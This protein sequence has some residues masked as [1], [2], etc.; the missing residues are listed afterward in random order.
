VADRAEDKACRFACIFTLRVIS[1][2][3]WSEATTCQ[4]PQISSRC[5]DRFDKKIDFTPFDDLQLDLKRL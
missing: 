3:V 4:V 2:P 1:I 5:L